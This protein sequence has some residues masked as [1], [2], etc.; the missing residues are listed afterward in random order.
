[1]QEVDEKKN[2]YNINGLDDLGGRSQTFWARSLFF[3]GEIH[4]AAPPGLLDKWATDNNP[5]CKEQQI[6]SQWFFLHGRQVEFSGLLFIPAR[7]YFVSCLPRLQM[8]SERF[9]EAHK[10][11][12]CERRRSE[13]GLSSLAL[14][15]PLR[16]AEATLFCVSSCS[17][18]TFQDKLLDFLR[19]RNGKKEVAQKKHKIK[20]PLKFKTKT[21]F[22][23][24]LGFFFLLSQK[25]TLAASQLEVSSSLPCWPKLARVRTSPAHL[26]NRT[27]RSQAVSPL[28][29]LVSSLLSNPWHVVI[30][31]ERYF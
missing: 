29:L 7:I 11:S 3:K 13:E 22:L 15:F 9:D 19:E 31:K 12:L 28:V 6:L 24:E 1:M 30:F 17:R 20:N 26:A 25:D 2:F 8:T 14:C 18:E 23:A 21:T 27:G 16:A 10:T 4:R 5:V